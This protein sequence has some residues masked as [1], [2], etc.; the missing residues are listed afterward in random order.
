[1]ERCWRDENRCC[2]SGC[3][4]R[5]R[6]GSRR[7]CSLDCCSRNRRAEPAGHGAARLRQHLPEARMKRGIKRAAAEDRVTQSPDMRMFDMRAPG[8]HLGRGRRFVQ[9][10]G[11][12]AEGCGGY[13]AGLRIPDGDFHIS[14]WLPRSVVQLPLQPQ[15]FPLQ[16]SGE[17]R[18]AGLVTFSADCPPPRCMQRRE[19]CDLTIQIVTTPGHGASSAR[20]PHTGQPRRSTGRHV[21]SACYQS[22]AAHAIA[23]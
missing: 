1:M 6:C 18:R 14:P 17:R 15:Q 2:C 20:S 19:C 11:P 22:T 9:Y 5:C 4:P 7:G 3:R 13:Q 10:A 12:N 8:S 23:A 16:P 21:H